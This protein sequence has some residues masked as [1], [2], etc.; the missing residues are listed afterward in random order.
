MILHVNK[1]QFSFQEFYPIDDLFW[2]ISY[3]VNAQV[4]NNEGFTKCATPEAERSRYGDQYEELF[5]RFEQY[6]Q[7]QLGALNRQTGQIY[8]IPIIFH[9]IHNGEAVGTGYNIGAQYVNAQ[10]EQ[11]NN[12]FRKILGSSGEGAGVDTQIEFCAAVTDENGALLAEP[13][14]DRIDRNSKGWTAPP[15]GGC[16]FGFLFDNAYIQTNIKPNSIWDPTQYLN[17]WVMDISCDI[18][19]YAQFPETMLPGITPNPGA[20]NTD[21]V[22]VLYSS[23]GSTDLP[24]PSAEPYNK[25]RT[26]THEVGHWLGLRH[27]WGDGDCTEDDFCTDTPNAGDPNYGCPN[28]DSCP[29]DPGRDQVENYMDYTDDDCMNIFTQCQTDRMRIVMGETN[30]GSPR[31]QELLSST[32]CN[33]EGFRIIAT[34]SPVS[35]FQPEEAIFN[36]EVNFSGSFTAPVTLS[37]AG[38]PIGVTATF[39]TNPVVTEGNYTLTIDGTGNVAPGTYNFTINGTDGD[40]T[41]DSESVS[42]VVVDPN[43]FCVTTNSTNVPIAIPNQTTVSSTI[44]INTTGVVTD[45]NVSFLGAHMAVRD[46]IFELRSPSGTTVRLVD[47]DVPCN[48]QDDFDL[49]F[50]DEAANPISSIPCPPVDGNFYQPEQLLSAFIGEPTTGVWTLLVTDDRT[51]NTGQLN[52][53][54]LDI[55]VTV[56]QSSCADDLVI[57]NNPIV[58]DTYSA[59]DSIVSSGVVEVDSVVVF[60]AG[61]LVRLTAGFTAQSGADFTARIQ[62]CNPVLAQNKIETR[63]QS[64]VRSSKNQ[65]S[66]YPNP[67]T[68]QTSIMV[69]L[70]EDAVVNMQIVDLTGKTVGII[71]TPKSLAAGKHLFNTEAIDLKAGVYLLVATMDGELQTTKLFVIK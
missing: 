5:D 35:A 39:S 10:I 59:K 32:A 19:G 61:Q 70:A 31:R 3:Y 29:S 21:G 53:W 22:V 42:L 48:A 4:S 20:A 41:N 12:D 69:E 55:C 24:F 7:T 25:G 66:V 6:I 9:V 18:L 43:N 57:D 58:S 40:V 65:L 23:V 47:L 60:E 16:V 63:T 30:M 17:I 54:Q 34:N 36:F 26:L 45:V 13:G 1:N 38:L 51:A 68:E 2:M 14:I 62:N 64:M 46:L 56:P 67:F 8:Q 49:G 27:I 28:A 15:Y 52:A 33:F 50:D 71:N 44:T 11:L 37:T